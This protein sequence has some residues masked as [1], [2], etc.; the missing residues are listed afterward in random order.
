MKVGNLKLAVLFALIF[1]LTVQFAFGD[2]SNRYEV[3]PFNCQFDSLDEAISSA[4]SGA[5]ILIKEGN[6]LENVSVNKDIVLKGQT[7]SRVAV[8]GYT[9]KG[10]ALKIGPSDV[11]VKIKNVTFS[12]AAA[13]LYVTGEAD[14]TLENCVI[15]HN[16]TGIL[17]DGMASLDVKKSKIRKNRLDK[18]N[19]TGLKIEDS[20]EVL[21]ENSMFL[22]N[23]E[24]VR[25][26]DFSS[27]KI[28]NSTITGNVGTGLLLSGHPAVYLEGND[29]IGS[30]IYGIA[31]KNSKCGFGGS[32]ESFS[33]TIAGKAN[34]FKETGIESYCPSKLSFLTGE[35]EGEYQG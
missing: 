24:G 29:F 2:T 19:G 16:K 12:R 17:V 10:P 34:N 7:D 1:L 4:K 20:S 28:Y 35:E 22:K 33:G 6:Y 30:Y 3:C 11:E 26:G 18:I 13:G 5:T 23:T 27:L 15:S 8:K 32:A 31:L 9:G 21:I 25:V 14:V